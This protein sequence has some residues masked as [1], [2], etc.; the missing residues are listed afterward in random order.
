M[1]DGLVP[2]RAIGERIKEERTRL[3]L[4]VG[5]FASVAGVSDRSQRNYE[6]GERLPDA[7]Y[8]A[9]AKEID[10]DVEYLLTGERSVWKSLASEIETQCDQVEKVVMIL[11][12]ALQAKGMTLDVS[13]KARSVRWL[14]RAAAWGAPVNSTV[15]DELLAIIQE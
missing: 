4:S 15:V 14:Y 1:Q 11:E 8:L 10:V 6:S 12:D 9:R 3:N 13:Q 2:L 5:E 7:E